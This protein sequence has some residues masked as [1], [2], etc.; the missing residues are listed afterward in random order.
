MRNRQPGNW[1]SPAL[2]NRQPRFLAKPALWNRQPRIRWS[3]RGHWPCGSRPGLPCGVSRWP[4]R[5]VV[6]RPSG[7]GRQRRGAGKPGETGRRGAWAQASNPRQAELYMARV[8]SE[9]LLSRERRSRSGSAPLR[10]VSG[11]GSG[12]LAPSCWAGIMGY[13]RVILGNLNSSRM[14]GIRGA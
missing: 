8:L 5:D 2:R 12:A 13:C 14:T 3:P 7:R 6:P 4:P 9:T 1:K 10:R 11:A